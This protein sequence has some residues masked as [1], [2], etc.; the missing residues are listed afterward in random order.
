MGLDQEKSLLL[1][2]R[3]R[4]DRVLLW[5]DIMEAVI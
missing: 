3:Y 4:S 2:T 1:I 5:L